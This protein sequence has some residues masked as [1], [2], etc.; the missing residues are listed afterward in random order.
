M[1]LE[2]AVSKIYKLSIHNYNTECLEWVKSK[3]GNGYGVIYCRG[4][5]A[6]THRIM[7]EFYNGPI[8]DGLFVMHECDN[9]SCSN[10]DHLR[11]GTPKD[12]SLDASR[13][14]R[15]KNQNMGKRYCLKGHEFTR[16]NTYVYA[17]GKKR[18]CIECIKLYRANLRSK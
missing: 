12:N 11:I 14:G 4:K 9:P 3:A 18:N 1:N 10:I 17:N 6:Y 5:Q 2:K 8:L 7:Y 15:S 16:E 13:K